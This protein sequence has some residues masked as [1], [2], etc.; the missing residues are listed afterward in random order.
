[1]MLI[2][3]LNVFCF[4]HILM[5][6]LNF[7][8]L[9]CSILH[10]QEYFEYKIRFPHSYEN[11]FDL[12]YENFPYVRCSVPTMQVG[13]YNN[14]QGITFQSSFNNS[15]ISSAVNDWAKLHFDQKRKVFELKPIFLT[16]FS[17]SSE[18]W[19]KFR[20]NRRQVGIST[21]EIQDW[22]RCEVLGTRR[23]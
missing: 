1:M 15:P 6:T 16:I 21:S 23:Y 22:G 2:C 9:N 12:S 10:R 14:S 18:P 11:C 13:I 5:E 4:L 7:L 8:M 20:V 3:Q 19:R 17:F